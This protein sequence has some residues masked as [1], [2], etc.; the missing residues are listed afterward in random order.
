M[1]GA[2]CRT[3]TDANGE[4]TYRSLTN[5][6]VM[7]KL[8]FAP[9]SLELTLLSTTCEEAGQTSTS[10]C[11]NCSGSIRLNPNPPLLQMEQCK[12]QTRGWTNSLRIWTTCYGSIRQQN[13]CAVCLQ[14]NLSQCLRMF[15]LLFCQ[16]GPTELRVRV[17]SVRIPPPGYVLPLLLHPRNVT[18]RCLRRPERPLTMFVHGALAFLQRSS[19]RHHIET[20]LQRGHCGKSGGPFTVGT[21]NPP[22]SVVC[23][24][25]SVLSPSLSALLEFIRSHFSHVA[26]TDPATEVALI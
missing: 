14:T 17:L 4:K 12:N 18:P 5:A 19:A 9:L 1:R 24:T 7:E 15:L 20:T 21:V 2:S 6:Q 3:G 10:F 16:V 22:S 26:R 23:P 25:C 13:F 8:R 11:S